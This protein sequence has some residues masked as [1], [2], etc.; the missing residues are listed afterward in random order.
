MKF[1]MGALI[2]AIMLVTGIAQA[3]QTK[4]EHS[5]LPQNGFVPDEATA[6]AIAEAVWIPIY[7]KKTIQR[8]KPIKAVLKGNVWVVT[9][10]FNYVGANGGV[11]LAEISKSDAKIIRVTHGM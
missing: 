10:T 5:Y 2:L 8:E 6:V 9:G 3:N 11:A 7:G 1:I 4:V